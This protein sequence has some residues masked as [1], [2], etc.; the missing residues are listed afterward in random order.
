MERQILIFIALEVLL[1]SHVDGLDA[2]KG[3]RI[4]NRQVVLCNDLHVRCI[5]CVKEN[6]QDFFD[7]LVREDLK[8]IVLLQLVH[9]DAFDLSR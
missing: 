3:K 4:E 1:E 6:L 7:L 9:H 2:E 5:L 8:L